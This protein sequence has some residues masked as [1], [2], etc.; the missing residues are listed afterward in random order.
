VVS[1]NLPQTSEV[2]TATSEDPDPDDDPCHP[3]NAVLSLR[4]APGTGPWA[5]RSQ[6]L[7]LVEA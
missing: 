5:G 4:A 7:S 3:A 2:V 6:S 1:S